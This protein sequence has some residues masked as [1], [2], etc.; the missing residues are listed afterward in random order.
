MA[1][2]V[3]FRILIISIGILTIIG[4]ACNIERIIF[5][6]TKFLQMEKQVKDQSHTDTYGVT[7]YSLEYAKKIAITGIVVTVVNLIA[8]FPI[9]VTAS[10]DITENKKKR[11]CLLPFLFSEIILVLSILAITVVMCFK[12]ASLSGGGIL[13]L[14][15]NILSIYW[16]IF[17]II[18]VTYYYNFLGKY[19]S[20]E[21]FEYKEFENENPRSSLELHHNDGINVPV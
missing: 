2:N 16:S 4:T 19:S 21:H 12:Y 14:V 13:E 11:V 18:V 20:T 9:F 6:L 5:V 7:I 1:F 8:T 17:V 3:N 10:E 15:F